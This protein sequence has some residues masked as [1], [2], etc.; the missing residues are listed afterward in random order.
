MTRKTTQKDTDKVSRETTKLE[1]IKTNRSL[2]EPVHLLEDEQTGDRFLLYAD[3]KGIQVQ[4]H[5]EGDSLW[6]TQAQLATLFGRDVSVISR[7]INNIIDDDEL[8]AESNLQK[9]QIVSSTTKD[10]YTAKNYLGD[11]EIRDLNRFTGML[12][13]YFEQETDLQRLVTMD[14][15]RSALD[16]FIRNNERALL[17]GP[18]SISKIDADAYVKEQYKIFTDKLRALSQD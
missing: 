4:I 7:H 13:D 18:G 6:M 15:A 12:L 3:S 8:D 5:Y 9:M 17:N 2:N 16:K 10:I 11:A 1:N 14:D